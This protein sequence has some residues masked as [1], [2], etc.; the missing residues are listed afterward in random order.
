VIVSRQHHDLIG[1]AEAFGH[2]TER[3]VLS[4]EEGGRLDNNEKL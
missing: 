2:L 4:I 1:Y 3:R